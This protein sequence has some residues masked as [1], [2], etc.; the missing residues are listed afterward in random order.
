MKP[1][2]LPSPCA[3]EPGSER[4]RVAGRGPPK[5]HPPCQKGGCPATGA[6]DISSSSNS[7]NSS[8]ARRGGAGGVLSVGVTGTGDTGVQAAEA[9]G[10]R[11]RHPRAMPSPELR[12][13]VKRQPAAGTR[14]RAP[15]CVRSPCQGDPSARPILSEGLLRSMRSAQRGRPPHDWRCVLRA[16]GVAMAAAAAFQR[17]RVSGGL[18]AP[19]AWRAT[20]RDGMPREWLSRSHRRWAVTSRPRARC[21]STRPAARLHA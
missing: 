16:H 15:H 17:L 13:D 12:S 11:G 1:H 21:H 4:L 6:E 10:G 2:A 20:G 7:S 3:G 19:T 9:H 18:S 5:A 8:S 14:H